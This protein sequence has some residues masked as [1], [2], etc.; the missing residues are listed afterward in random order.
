M[1]TILYFILFLAISSLSH[2]QIY[3]IDSYGPTDER[4]EALLEPNSTI[5]Q[6]DL[7]NEQILDLVDPSLADSVFSRKKQHHKVGPFGWFIH[8]FGGLNW[9]AT[10]MNKEKI[11]GTV[12]G[13]SRSGKELFTEYDIIYDLI[14]HMPRYQKLMFKQYD[15]QLEIRRQDKLKKERINYDA[16]PFVRDT[17]NIDL[18]LYKLHC[19]V[20]PH[21]D[22]L[23]NLHYVLFPTLPDGTGLKDHPN[24][25]NSHPSVG[26]FGVL[27][28]DCN[29]DC[30]PEMHPYEW[31]WWLKCTDDD[32]SFNKEWHIG[33]FL[34]G[35]NRMKKWSTNPRTGA[36]NI[37][38]AFRIDENAVIEIE[39]GLHG[40]F[41][42]DSTF[43]LPE[44]TFNASAENRMIQIQGNGV[45]KSIEIRT[46]NP[47][48]NSTI[49]YWLSDLNYDEANQVISGNLFMFVSVMDVYTVTVRF[50]NE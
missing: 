5:S 10:S 27:C 24:F 19:E 4:Y 46:C 50:I 22:Y 21:E 44:N 43:L 33:L 3:T 34:E 14:F 31:M 39:H 36:V 41:V 16:P 13:Y 15:A 48:E 30:H 32:Q 1:R 35:S 42:Q 47:I 37:P 28:L 29:H 8:F 26:M 49:Q 45:E 12:A 23:H 38:F 7:L 20:T 25:M 6:N 40:E 17:N 11:V 2:A 9:R 18:D